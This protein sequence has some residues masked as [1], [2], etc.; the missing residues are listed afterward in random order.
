MFVQYLP[1]IIILVALV[2]IVIFIV[3][4]VPKIKDQVAEVIPEAEPSSVE[5][6]IKSKAFW[7]KFRKIISAV[8]S[9]TAKG[10]VAITKGFG[11]GFAMIKKE[12]NKKPFIRKEKAITNVGE[13]S[14]NSKDN[15]MS[16]ASAV[17]NV[18]KTA[19]A[20]KLDE[21]R[22]LKGEGKFQE[23]EKIYIDLVVS[24]PK[25]PKP[26]EELGRVYMEMQNFKDASASFEQAISL[27]T[28]NQNNIY[29]LTA[30]CFFKSELY[31]KALE[32]AELAIDVDSKDIE[33]LK[34]IVGVHRRNKNEMLERIALEKIVAIN[35]QDSESVSRLNTLKS[36]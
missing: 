22:K 17:K 8:F 33:S 28:K 1:Q 19:L 7:E 12:I 15:M 9:A 6:K 21:A 13:F 25:S 27:G 18:F 23:A 29:P 26:Y 35:P 34:V 24:N 4:K 32:Y 10:V 2:G 3:R 5:K 11:A 36:I 16:K 31:K 30:K 20:K 14:E